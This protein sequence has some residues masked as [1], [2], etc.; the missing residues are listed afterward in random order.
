[1]RKLTRSR[2]GE[3]SAKQHHR[4]DKLKIQMPAGTDFV[5][6]V[7]PGSLT[8]SRH[9]SIC[10]QIWC[11]SGTL[12]FPALQWNDFSVRVVRWW[13]EAAVGLVD[14]RKRK[15]EVNFMDGPY[16]VRVFAKCRELW[17]GEFVESRVVGTKVIH[18]FDFAPDPLIRSL[19]AC[20]DDL[21]Q[22]C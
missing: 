13:L 22:E 2:A 14:G 4:F 11:E 9:G 7:Q 5:L 10:G 12:A 6:R 8:R 1:M 20:S 19:I 17:Q 21:L 16:V 15:A 18:Q 3:G